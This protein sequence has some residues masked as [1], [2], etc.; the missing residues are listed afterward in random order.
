MDRPEQ[1]RAAPPAEGVLSVATASYRNRI[2][3]HYV[4]AFKG[5]RDPQDVESGFRKH[6]AMFDA[7]L[8][9]L[10]VEA[11]PQSVLEVACGP[12]AFLHWARARGV[13][14]V[15]G[16]DISDEQV[17]V[18]KSLDL[19]AEV[20]S[21]VDFLRGRRE[22]FDLIVGMDIVEHLVRDEVFELLDMCFVALRPG[23]HVF[24]TTPNGAGLRPGPTRYGDLT[25][26]TIF[27]P[28]TIDLALRLSGYEP[29]VVQEIIPP[30]S[31]LRAR[32]RRG[33]WRIVRLWPMILDLVETGSAGQRVYTRNMAV[34]ARKP[35]KLQE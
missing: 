25:H 20:A 18:A 5:R 12:G 7:L 22:E 17:E 33:L 34:R 2:Y 32:V 8:G 16:F 28:Q 1:G 31:S 4:S 30:P 26:E 14:N 24:F 15:V 9:A 10:L 35:Q 6:F 11:H 21:Y 29:A 27:T 23:G 3:R 19:P 13:P